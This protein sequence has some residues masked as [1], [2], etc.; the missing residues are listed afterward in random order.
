MATSDYSSKFI[1][2]QFPLL[3][4]HLFFG[5]PPTFSP[6]KKPPM[7]RPVPSSSPPR[8]RWDCHRGLHPSNCSSSRWRP[9]SGDV[10]PKA[11]LFGDGKKYIYTWWFIPLSK[12][13]VH[14]SYKWINPTKIPCKSLGF[15]LTHNH[16]SWVVRHQVHIVWRIINTVNGSP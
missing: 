6:P 2:L 5:R 16:D 4:L 10:F 13:V 9:R 8:W 1:H 11:V 15:S 14:P 12:W 3:N 7:G